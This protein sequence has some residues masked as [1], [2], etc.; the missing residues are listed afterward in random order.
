MRL[1]T[2]YHN[3]RPKDRRRARLQ[4]MEEQGNECFYCGESFDGPPLKAVTDLP[5]L[6]RLFP[7]GF[8]K[9]PVHLHHDH[10]TGMTIGAVH[11]Y[12]NAVMWQYEGQ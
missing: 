5:V 8:F 12:C 10:N 4:Y 9:H 11:N 6:K 2:E 7:P 3:L 1:P